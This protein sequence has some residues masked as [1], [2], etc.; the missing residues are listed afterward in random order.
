MAHKVSTIVTRMLYVA[1]CDSCGDSVEHTED[2]GKERF[3]MR[4]S[5]WIPFVELSFTGPE[6]SRS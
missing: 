3:C 2:I 1:K 6:F 4:C 5:K